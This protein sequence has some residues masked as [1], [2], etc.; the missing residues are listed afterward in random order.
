M[1]KQYDF[2]K[3]KLKKNPFAKMMKK[4][5]SIRVDNDVLDYF[6]DQADEL[7]L[8]YQTLINM[9]LRDIV[10]NKRKLGM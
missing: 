1:R 7:G 6:Q 3:M 9:H 8:K 2:A 10:K 4:P 5:I